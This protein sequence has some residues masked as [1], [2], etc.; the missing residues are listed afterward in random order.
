MLSEQRLH[1]RRNSSVRA[2]LSLALPQ[3]KQ[4]LSGAPH[5]TPRNTLR[6]GFERPRVG[7]MLPVYQR[8]KRCSCKRWRIKR[9]HRR[10][11]GRRASVANRVA[12]G[13][14]W[15]G[16]VASRDLLGGGNILCRRGFPQSDNQRAPGKRV[17]LTT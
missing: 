14:F 13:E 3:T 2:W 5:G 16:Q 4:D 9:R 7:L 8:V 12:R 6:H 10:R 1:A 11:G 17:E 15:Y